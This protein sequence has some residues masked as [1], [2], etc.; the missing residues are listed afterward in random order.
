MTAHSAPH[1]NKWIVPIIGLA[2]GAMVA[3]PA[4]AAVQ[5]KE[6]QKCSTGVDKGFS[7]TVKAVGK[8]MNSCIKDISKSKATA[9]TCFRNDRKGKILKSMLK[10][11]ASHAGN[12]TDNLPDFGFAGA[13]ITVVTAKKINI[14][15]PTIA[16]REDYVGGS[17]VASNS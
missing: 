6:Q 14:Y 13:A 10:T 16:S 11:E 5:T 8:E 15:A 3:A 9:A 17:S 2:L 12:C 4:V 1:T 7:K